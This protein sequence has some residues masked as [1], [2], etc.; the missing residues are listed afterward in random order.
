MCNVLLMQNKVRSVAM[1]FHI[2]LSVVVDKQKC[3]LF[4]KS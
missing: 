1:W 2:V 3:G 4:A